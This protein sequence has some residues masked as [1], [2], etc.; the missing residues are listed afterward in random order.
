MHRHALA[1]LSLAL[2]LVLSSCEPFTAWYDYS[3]YEP[4]LQYS[5]R[6]DFTLSEEGP[7]WAFPGTS[8]RFRCNCTGVGVAFED[9]GTGGAEHTNWVNV[10]VDG[11]TEAKV[12]LVPG[13]AQMLRGARNL[14]AGE[15]TIE[16]VKRTEAYVGPVRFIGVGLQGILLDPPPRPERRLEIVGDSISCGYGNEASI[17]T[18][19]KYTEPNT[20]FNSKNEDISQ[21]YGAFLGQRFNAEVMHS[22][23]S[24]TGMYRNNTGATEGTYPDRYGRILPDD[25]ASVWDF[26]LFVPDIVIINLGNNDFNVINPEDN[27]PTAPEP[28]PFK[29]TYAR[30]VQRLRGYYPSAHIICSVGP[31]MNDNYPKDRQHWTKM[32]KYTSDMVASLGDPRVHYFA[33]TPIPTGPYGEDWHPTADSHRAMANEI[34]KFIQT[35][36]W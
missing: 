35:L 3:A 16:I 27:L 30:F 19:N 4:Q 10:I 24:G 31:M 33:Y 2:G 25:E 17:N 21:A 6:M 29:E 12:K 36:G 7:V 15:H 11:E 34:G 9:Q 22:C 1:W 5:G 26:S 20:G 18:S 23:I 8:V 28:A 32:Q 13:K 14:K